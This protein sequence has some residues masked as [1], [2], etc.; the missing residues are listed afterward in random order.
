MITSPSAAGTSFFSGPFNSPHACTD[1]LLIRGQIKESCTITLESLKVIKLCSCYHLF[2]FRSDPSL[3]FSP[4]HLSIPISP[5]SYPLVSPLSLH[6]SSYSYQCSRSF[7]PSTQRQLHCHPSTRLPRLFF[8]LFLLTFLLCFA[9][10]RKNV[11]HFLPIH[12]LAVT[13]LQEDLIL[14][15]Q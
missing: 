4:P 10:L 12:L 9:P 14:D 6:L 1:T 3:L 8:Y 11:V 15:R 13:L 2:S 7:T 5:F